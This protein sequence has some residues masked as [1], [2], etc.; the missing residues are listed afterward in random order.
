[1]E[2]WK[3]TNT[4]PPQ[5]QPE[6][7]AM[8]AMLAEREQQIMNISYSSERWE[9]WLQF[10]QNRLV[11]KFTT[12]GFELVQIPPKVFRKFMDRV[13]KEL[14]NY[15]AIPYE[16]KVDVIYSDHNKRPK[17]INMW[18]TAK[19]AHKDLLEYHELWGNNFLIIDHGSQNLVLRWDE[20][21]TH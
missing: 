14:E 1:V 20:A 13:N 12:H 18:D 15:D 7:P 9:N 16:G 5:W 3:A 6:T 2:L 4:W 8:K 11:P 21:P 19:E 10:T 17:F